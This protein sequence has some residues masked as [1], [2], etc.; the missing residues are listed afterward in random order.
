M[1]VDCK[2]EFDFREMSRLTAALDRVEK[3]PQKIVTKAASKGAKIAGDA[4]KAA[5]PVGK[6]GQLR[7][8]FKRY[9]E[10]GYQGKKVYQ[11]AIDENKNDIFQKEIPAPETKHPGR[12]RTN[13]DHAYYPASIEYGFLT[14]S[15]GGG[16]SY[17]PGKHFARDA[18][19]AVRPQVQST[20]IR[21]M[22]QELEKEWQK[23]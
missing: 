14:R 13:W 17:V 3:I 23:I 5:A 2:I 10:K 6:T 12:R 7:K 19:E 16:M 8:G 15:T 22:T 18:A 9:A 20:I 4:V 1:A 21:Y 11:Y